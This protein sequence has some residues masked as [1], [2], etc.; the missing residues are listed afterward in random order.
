MVRGWVL[1]AMG[2]AEAWC[3]QEY[4]AFDVCAAAKRCNG[5]GLTSS[6]F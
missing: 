2:E 4:S 6:R 1:G 3:H 5:K